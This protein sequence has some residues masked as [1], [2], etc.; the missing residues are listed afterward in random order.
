MT[1]GST[2]I[3]VEPHN[4]VHDEPMVAELG[5]VFLEHDVLT[6]LDIGCGDGFVSKELSGLGILTLGIDGYV[7]DNHKNML[8]VRHDLSAPLITNPFDAVT[9]FE[10][11]EHIPAEFED[12]F[13]KNLIQAEPRILVVSW[14]KPGQNGKGHVNCKPYEYISTRLSSFGYKLDEVTTERLQSVSKRYWHQ[15]NLMFLSRES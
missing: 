9:S 8:F 13:F 1:I 11:G 7:V 14:A 15:N 12:I 6:S 5:K 4:Y 3:W 10:V 2:G